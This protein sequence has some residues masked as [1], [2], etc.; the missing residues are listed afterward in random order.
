MQ[1]LLNAVIK[2]ASCW[3][4][5]FT[6]SLKGTQF[7]AVTM[8]AVMFL[9]RESL[10]ITEQLV[11]NP[12]HVTLW[13]STTAAYHSAGGTQPA[14]VIGTGTIAAHLMWHAV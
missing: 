14:H 1:T 7:I 8:T 3:R 6:S 10:H 9:E 13:A 4:D 2:T 12:P 5:H 11:H